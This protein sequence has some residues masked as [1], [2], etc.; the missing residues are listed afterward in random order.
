MDSSLIDEWEALKDPNAASLAKDLEAAA[1][2]KAAAERD[3]RV[4]FSS[5][6]AFRVMVRNAAFRWVQL[7]AEGE[8]EDMQARPRTPLRVTARGPGRRT[9]CTN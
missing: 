6:R 8:L 1:A 5:G 2:L 4:V 7:L 3:A 9:R